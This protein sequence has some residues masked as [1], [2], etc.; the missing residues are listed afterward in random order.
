VA[1]GLARGIGFEDVPAKSGAA[2]DDP[3]TEW[4]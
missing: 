3:K 4:G 2:G 1:G